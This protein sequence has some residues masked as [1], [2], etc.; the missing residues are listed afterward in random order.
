[1]YSRRRFL[2]GLLFFVPVMFAPSALLKSLDANPLNKTRG[3]F[4]KQGWVLQEG[5]I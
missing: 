4:M 3:K 5:D 1:M 2:I